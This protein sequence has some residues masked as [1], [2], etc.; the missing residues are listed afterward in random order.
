MASRGGFRT[1]WVSLERRLTPTSQDR[2][3]LG[4][5]AAE[6][7][8]ERA[9]PATGAGRDERGRAYSSYSTKRLYVSKSSPPRPKDMPAPKGGAKPNRKRPRTVR[10]EG[11]YSQYRASIG[12][13]SGANKNL[14]LTG[15]T[16]RSLRLLRVQ[17]GGVWIGFS[18]R[19]DRV[20]ALDARYRFMGFTRAEKKRLALA[21][22][23]IIGA[24]LRG[25]KT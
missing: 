13:S 15:Q 6:L 18:K 4:L 9:F 7:L 2:R 19:R 23:G 21:W 20:R 25:G 10:Y 1:K 11:G 5:L 14:V 16:A 12:R 24:K 8:R 22:A 3:K 17:Q